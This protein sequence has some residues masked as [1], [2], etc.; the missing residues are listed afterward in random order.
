MLYDNDWHYEEEK[1]VCVIWYSTQW[2]SSGQITPLGCSTPADRVLSLR[3]CCVSLC[4]EGRHPECSPDGCCINSIFAHCCHCP[5]LFIKA[6]F[7]VFLTTTGCG[8]W[9]PLT[10][11]LLQRCKNSCNSWIQA[12]ATSAG[13]FNQKRAAWGSS[14]KPSGSKS[15]ADPSVQARLHLAKSLLS[16]TRPPTPF[17]LI[18]QSGLQ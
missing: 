9:S 10:M 12:A 16:G 13:Q 15:A 2:D 4:A 11:S 8:L 14:N 17:F 6:R 18:K 5:N 1:E 3:T 7:S